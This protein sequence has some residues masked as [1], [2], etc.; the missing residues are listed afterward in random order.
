MQYLFYLFCYLLGSISFSYVLVKVF[1]NEDVRDKGSKNA[2]ATNV[3]RN[4]GRPIGFFAFLLDYGKGFLAAFLSGH[5]NIGIPILAVFFADLGHIFPIFLKFKGGKGVATT[6]GGFSAMSPSS[7]LMGFVVFG[8]FAFGTGYASVASMALMAYLFFY[9]AMVVLKLQGV[10]LLIAAM[11]VLMV[12]I[13]HK[14]NIIRLIN[15]K[16]NS[17]RKGKKL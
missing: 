16:E 2:G 12:I 14:D 4:Y 7:I 9:V 3:M 17:I 1:K 11:S 8:V 13:C 6:A 5:F 10:E 15:G